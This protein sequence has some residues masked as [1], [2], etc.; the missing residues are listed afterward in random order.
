MAS[1][2]LRLEEGDSNLTDL[3]ELSSLTAMCDSVYTT[4]Q[5][6]TSK[7]TPRRRALS[8]CK[9]GRYSSPYQVVDLNNETTEE[10][11]KRLLEQEQLIK[12]IREDRDTLQTKLIDKAGLNE[13]AVVEH[14]IRVSTQETK[15]Y[16]RD[17]EV[18]E[19]D[20][21]L[22]QKE[23]RELQDK[24][25]SLEQ[26]NQR[27][28]ETIKTGSDDQKEIEEEL[29]LLRKRVL[30]LEK[31]NVFKSEEI[32]QKNEELQK[33]MDKLRNLSEEYNRTMAEMASGKRMLEEKLDKYRSRLKES[34]RKSLEDHK[35]KENTQK[36]LSEVKQL[37]S[38]IDFL[39]PVRKDSRLKKEND[40][41][42]E[43]SAKLI[44]ETMSELKSKNAKLEEDLAEKN[45]LVKRT[46]EELE[47][48]KK[49]MDAAMGDSDTATK[50]LQEEN[51]RLTRQKAD[52]RC[53]LIDARR[54][55]TTFD[56]KKAELEKQR[57]D[58]LEEVKR[59][60]ELKKR[61]EQELEELTILA[62]QREQQ[63]EELQTRIAGLEVI[64]REHD[65][66]KNELS[67]T[68][69]KLN[70]MGRH[71][72]MADKQCTH[73]KSLK[74]TAEGSRRRAIEQCNEMV[75]RI[76]G[77]EASLENQRKVEQELETLR[78]EN[79]R[80]V[81]KIEY[82][83]EEI[84]E[85]HKDY[86][87]EL[88]T[89]SRQKSEERRNEEDVELL[90]LTLSKRESELRSA[91]KTI[92]EVK[93]DN[94]K[95]QQI[96]DEVRRQQDKILE[97]NVRLR[98]GITEALEKIQKHKQNWENS[99]DKCKRLERENADFEAKVNKLEEELLEKNQ[100]VTE[101][102]E[103]VAYLHT[104][105]NAK[106][107]KQPKLGR[108]STLLSTV[109]EMD[110]TV[111]SSLQKREAEEM[112]ALEEER[113]KLMGDLAEKRRILAD[114][115]R[116]QSTAN[117]TVVTTTT[118]TT[119][120]SKSASEL[121]QR[122]GTMRHD[123]PH[124]W[125]DTRHYGVLSIKCSLC[126]VGIACLGKMRICRHCGI[127]VHAACAPR[128]NNTCGMP[129][130]CATYYQ[131]N[132]TTVSDVP[133]GRMNGWLRVYQDDM[134]GSTWI[135][136]WA[137]MD[138]TRI[139]F[140]NNDGAD[141]D[142]PFL[143]IDLNQE[144]WVL[145]TGQEM[146]VDCDDSMRA[147]SALMIKMPRKSL[148]ILA[149]SQKAAGR[150]AACLQTAQRKRMMLNSKPSSI[151]EF[152]CLLVLNSPN[153]LRIYK[154][155]TIEDWILFAT[156]TGLFFT[157]ISQPRS[158]IR[159]SGVMSVTSLEIMSEINCIA[160][161][162]NQKRQLALI[163]MDSL[164]LAMQSTQ[165]SIRPEILPELKNVHTVRYHQQSSGQRYLLFSDDTHLHIRKYSSTKDVFSSF[166]KLD[167]PE[168]VSFVESTPNGIIFA[169]DTF[170]YVPLDS[171][172]PTP[173]R[174]MPPRPADYPVS[175]FL[176]S[177][178]EVLLAYQNH[179]IFVNLHGE[180][181][182]LTTIEW[183]KMP[184]EFTYTAPFLYVV[185]DD[186][187]EILEVSENREETIIDERELFECSNAHI[188][189]RQYQGVLISVSSS[190]STE[191][192]RFSTSSGHRQKN[193]KR[194]G[195]SPSNTL[196]RIKN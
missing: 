89:L 140:Y 154:A 184:M 3:H 9:P 131:E 88:T 99:Q 2:C 176:I 46:K 111:Y 8:P 196:K 44:K 24:C 143:W 16:S 41:M 195:T 183:E 61:V 118:T 153:N 7:K 110:T 157:S 57:D 105:I 194:R 77:L 133:E 139:A 23:I 145:R 177:Q 107:N 136:S 124:K 168:P 22:K 159:I 72:E 96:L 51:M 104:Q 125:N 43:F 48:L 10:L 100:Q 174:L 81:Q 132:Q 73:F 6:V 144:Q 70:Q 162:V 56:Q 37:R 190:E 167:V 80:Q 30:D 164:T 20:L 47:A 109:S 36:V 161:V 181:T 21:A 165:P 180:P 173:R 60:S 79:S 175:A 141:M 29:N 32:Y 128:V 189:G 34:D 19:K 146:P 52:I 186:S 134:P 97:E 39:T 166:I 71:L 4:P 101:S 152:S 151:A 156:Q 130:Q 58:A 63:I 108:R 85:V 115:K 179:G 163:P 17:I 172:H 49:S 55:L 171:T 135:A 69:E 187:I 142:K 123:I 83:K 103:T 113:Q 169:S 54:Q 91:R 59:I 78:A 98:Q 170:Y 11:K 31:E 121:T 147:N 15:I 193:P 1:L 38:Q 120:V 112:L 148:Y 28:V 90:K 42:L 66:V 191:V 87:Q 158:P 67:K 33:M 26:E 50:F 25:R 117:T 86:R 68:N 114:S 93:A 155:V 188:I 18:L 74:E 82:M 5:S 102:E 106:Q 75:V 40:E 122:P 84:Q 149:P 27:M 126:F 76:R 129:V 160:M 182:R 13:S 127:Q 94:L 95:V 65:S 138:L 116:S 64:K 192:H 45:E 185:H 150:W 14:S 137:R 12:D 35:E 178:N 92:E 62:T 53:D 119:E